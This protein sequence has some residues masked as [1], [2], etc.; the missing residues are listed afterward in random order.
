[1]SRRCTSAN[2]LDAWV[3]IRDALANPNFCVE[4]DDSETVT[5]SKL[6]TQNKIRQAIII[7]SSFIANPERVQIDES[8]LL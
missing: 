8:K 7:I 2:A 6:D 5:R 1:M 3:V 4:E